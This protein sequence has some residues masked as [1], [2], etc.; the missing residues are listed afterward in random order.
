MAF[1]YNFESNFEQGSNAEWD[2][3]TDNDSALDFPSYKILA[4]VGAEPYIGAYCMRLA[5][6]GT[7]DA[8]LSEG[9]IDIAAGATRYIRF[10]V[11]VSSNFAGGATDSFN[12]LE[13]QQTG[14][15]VEATF[16]AKVTTS[17]NVVQFGIGETAPT[18]LTQAI[19]KGVWNTVE[20]KVVCDSGGNNDGTID[21][22]L[23]QQGHRTATGVAATQV[24]TLDQGAIGQGVLG[25]Q[26]GVATTTGFI[27]IDNFAMDDGRL[28]PTLRFPPVPVLTKSRH[29]ILGQGK[30]GIISL[31]SGGAADNV[32]RVWDT[33]A[34]DTTNQS[35][36][37]LELRNTA[38]SQTVFSQEPVYVRHGAYVELSGTNPRATVKVEHGNHSAGAI[39]RL[40]MVG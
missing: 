38:A 5:M 12:L 7:N 14:G 17:T 40:G 10:D 11:Y 28:Y 24:G 27:L 25:L 13:L 30:L 31:L 37:V 22:Y 39:R 32:L 2:S 23:T 4:G 6:G 29:V 1:P 26:G 16:G 19:A 36:L 18:S 20:L 35:N 34:A 33:D 8:I 15:T 21:L 3:E 9:D